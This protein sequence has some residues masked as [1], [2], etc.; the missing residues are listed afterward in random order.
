MGNALALLNFPKGTLFNRASSSI[1]NIE[2]LILRTKSEFNNF[3]GTGGEL[4]WSTR[5]YEITNPKHHITNRLQIPIIND[6]NTKSV[7]N[8]ETG[9]P[10]AGWAV[11]AKR[12]Q[13]CS[14]LFV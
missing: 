10:P 7:W 1:F 8:L 2:N 4:F 14:L 3:A 11:Q 12:G 9:D 5:V 6:Q 13:F